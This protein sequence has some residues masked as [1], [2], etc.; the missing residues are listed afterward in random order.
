MLGWR[1]LAAGLLAKQEACGDALLVRAALAS[2]AKP[3]PRHPNLARGPEVDLPAAREHCLALSPTLTQVCPA[4]NP[5][6][7]EEGAADF[8]R[9]AP[10]RGS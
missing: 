5:A 2:G 10:C 3:S 8:K 7:A 1:S 9:S 4:R 6:V